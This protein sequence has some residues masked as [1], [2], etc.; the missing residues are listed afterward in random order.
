MVIKTETCRSDIIVYFNANFK[1]LTKLIKSAFVGE[2]YV[3]FKMH[4][5]TIKKKDLL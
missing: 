3:D 4:D 1:L 2:C 5:A